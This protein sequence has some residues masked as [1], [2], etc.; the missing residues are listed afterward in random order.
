MQKPDTNGQ[1]TNK[2]PEMSPQYQ[3]NK[4]KK[5]KKEFTLHFCFV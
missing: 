5:N 2:K 3:K 4:N 1:D